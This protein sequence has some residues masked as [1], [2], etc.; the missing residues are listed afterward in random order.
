MT[1]PSKIFELFVKNQNKISSVR[2]WKKLQ[3]KSEKSG[4][5]GYPFFPYKKLLKK[6][7]GSANQKDFFDLHPHNISQSIIQTDKVNK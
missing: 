6:K 7:N 5:I 4:K 1:L 3:E 2:F